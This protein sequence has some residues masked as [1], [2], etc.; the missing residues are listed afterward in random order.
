MFLQTSFAP[1]S[2]TSLEE[3]FYNIINDADMNN[4]YW[5]LTLDELAT[6]ETPEL[7]T[8]TSHHV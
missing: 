6:C 3:P 5:S 2:Y 8:Y 1:K 4:Q 7:S